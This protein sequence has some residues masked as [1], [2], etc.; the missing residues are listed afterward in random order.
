MTC[1]HFLS[2]LKPLDGANISG[3]SRDRITKGMRHM[4]DTGTLE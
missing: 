2:L 3:T 1:F 4:P